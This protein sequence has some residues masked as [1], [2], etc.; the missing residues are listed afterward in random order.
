MGLL[1]H[2]LQWGCIF[3][4]LFLMVGCS[5][6]LAQK[7]PEGEKEFLE[8]TCRL[9]K[10]ARDHPETSVRAQSHLKLAFLFV[11]YRNPQLNYTRALQEMESYLSL[12]PTKG[13]TDDFKNWLSVLKE[14]EKLQT[15]LEKAQKANRSLREEVAGLKE[16]IERLKSLDRQMEE[17]RRLT[18]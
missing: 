6:N 14:T 5:L 10:L 1:F 7:K 18:K 16:T 13:Q 15:G 11:N 4:L 3:L 12:V 2:R 9:E 17:K 8:E